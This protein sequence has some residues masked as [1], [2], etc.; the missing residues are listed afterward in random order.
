MSAKSA[1]TRGAAGGGPW[2]GMTPGR[3]VLLLVGVLALVFIF[4]N[5]RKVKIRLI[6]PEVTTPLWLA[7]L[8]VGLIGTLCGA[9]LFRRRGD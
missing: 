1:K 7:L 5:T 8:A 2:S 4:E 3:A 6:V 9:Y